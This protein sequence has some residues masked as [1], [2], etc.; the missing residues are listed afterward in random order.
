MNVITFRSGFHA[1]PRV[2]RAPQFLSELI[3][4]SDIHATPSVHR[5]FRY[6]IVKSVVGFS[7]PHHCEPIE[8]SA[9]RSEA[10]RRISLCAPSSVH[11][12]GV[13]VEDDHEAFH[14][15]E[16][17]GLFRVVTSFST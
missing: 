10:F 11:P 13:L 17:F 16:H 3:L 14:I 15:V 4:R 2:R 7:F 8:T 1:S 6:R 9:M 12:D 5:V